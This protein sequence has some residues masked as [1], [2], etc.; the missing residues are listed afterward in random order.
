MGIKLRELEPKEIARFNAAGRQRDTGFVV[1]DG[2][3]YELLGMVRG[4]VLTQTLEG[5]FGPRFEKADVQLLELEEDK[6][7]AS[8]KDKRS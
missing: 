1:A 8:K 7:P 2:T 5:K 3:I 6:K 4:K